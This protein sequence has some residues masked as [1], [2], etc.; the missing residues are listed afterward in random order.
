MAIPKKVEDRIISNLKKYQGILAY[1]KDRDISE[2][3]TVIIIADMLAD[4]FGYNKFTEI[5]TEFAIRSTYVDLAVKLGQDVR[6][7]I[8]AKAVGVSLKD[9][10]IK[11]AVD[12]GANHGIDWIILTNGIVWQ[13]YKIHFKQPIDKTLV[14]ELDVLAANP[15]NAKVHECFWNLSKEGFNKP[16]MTAFYQQQQVMSKYSVAAMILSDQ[17]ISVLRRELRR[18][19]PGIK[20]DEGELKEVLKNDVVKRELVDSEEAKKA[21]EHMRKCSKAFISS[22]Q[23]GKME[24]NLSGETDISGNKEM[25]SNQEPEFY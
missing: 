3:D 6:F 1:A 13:I 4:V 10:H 9:A 2:S 16:A 12:Y 7:L 14:Y 20:I 25:K 18:L 11:Q 22:K 17:L 15:R 23:K 5:T 8:E 19:N 21:C 24:N